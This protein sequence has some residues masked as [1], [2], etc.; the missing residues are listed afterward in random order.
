MSPEE[1]K[2][3]ILSDTQATELFNDR[4]DWECSLRC[5]EIAPRVVRELL[6]S[7][8]GIMALYQDNPVLGETILATI[9]AVSAQNPI[10]KRIFKFAGPSSN[11]LPDWGSTAIRATM[12]A[13]T[14]QGGLGLTEEQAGPI[15]R[16]A[17]HPPTITSLDI[18][19]VR[20]RT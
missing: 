15:L 18:E 20:N 12:L 17:E 9:E 3:L 6:L 14:A 4:K 2:A 13:P 10:V 5:M 8:L 1:L 7:E 16:A 11:N 19:F